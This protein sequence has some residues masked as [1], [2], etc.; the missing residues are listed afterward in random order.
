V[1]TQAQ[2]VLNKALGKRTIDDEDE[3][4]DERMLQAL[5]RPVTKK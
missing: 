2:Y 5:I 4:E 3:E 1:K